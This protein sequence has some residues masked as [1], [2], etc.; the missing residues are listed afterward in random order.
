MYF[1]LSGHKNPFQSGTIDQRGYN[2]DDVPPLKYTYSEHSKYCQP[3]DRRLTF[4][5]RDML[6]LEPSN[7][8]SLQDCLKRLS[9]IAA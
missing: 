6:Q 5:A 1:L 7:R 4:L 2:I 8:P 9:Q 3:L